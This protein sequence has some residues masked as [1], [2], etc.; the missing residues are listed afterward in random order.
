MGLKILSED[1]RKEVLKLNLKTP[2]DIVLGLVDL[3]GAAMYA[4]YLDALGKDAIIKTD[5]ASVTL[6]DPG[7]VVTD[8]IAPRIKDLNKNLK[9]PNDIKTGI[10]DL[11][12]SSAITQQYLAGRGLDTVI[13]D[14]NVINPGDVV[15]DSVTPRQTIL[16][17]NIKTPNDITTGIGNLTSNAGLT[18]QYL[19]GRGLD[20]VIGD[21][22]VFDP[23]TV[24][25]AANIERA[26]LLKKNKPYDSNDPSE[27]NSIYF[28]LSDG[29][30]TYT[31]LLDTINKLTIINDLS[32]PNST[33]VSID[34]N[35]TALVTL[36]LALQQNRYMPVQY[37]TF[38]STIIS[39]Q[40][41]LFTKPYIDAFNSGVYTFINPE[42]YT[43]SSFLSLRTTTSP[44]SIISGYNTDPISYFLNSSAT[45]ILENETL[46][47]NIAALELK[48][49]LESR[50]KRAIERET[51]GRTYLD[52]AMTNPLTAL[53]LLTGK[54]PLFEANYDITVPSNI[55]GKGAEF[56]ASLAGIT[57]PISFIKDIN[58]D[59]TP[60]CFGNTTEYDSRAKT[61]IGR[62]V[63]DL[64]GKTARSDKDIWY[65]NHTGSGQK[66]ALFNT[67]KRN[68][69]QPDYLIDYQSG[70]FKV[71]SKIAQFFKGITGF[72]GVGSGK[73]PTGFYYIGNKTR[74]E[75][76]FYLLQDADGDQV[77]S[78]EELI[79]V[80][81]HQVDTGTN[82]TSVYEEPGYD[83]VSQYGSLETD[84]VWKSSSAIDVVY[85]YKTKLGKH[86]NVKFTDDNK[87]SYI[88]NR[89]NTFRECSILYKTSQLLEKGI[90][91]FG[92]PIDQ[93]L[94]KF[95]DGYDFTSRGNATIAPVKIDKFNKQGEV[96]GYRYLIP[97]LDVSGKRNE[98]AM[99]YQAELCRV[100][101]KA[102]PYSKITDLVRYKELIRRERNSVLDR[103]GNLNIHP[104]ELNVN[105]GYGREKGGFAA[106]QTEAFGEKRARKYMFSLENLAW[107]D[108]AQFTDLPNCEKGFNG[109]RVMWFPPYDITF[110]D[111]T[112]ANWTTHQFLGRPEPIYTYNNSERSGS[113]SWKIVV[114]HPSI[115]NLLTQKELAKLTDGEID[116][117]LAAFWA[118]CVEFD[119]FELARIWNQFSQS[120][121][122]YFK[123]VIAGLN[124]KIP[125]EAIKKKIEKITVTK[126]P[127]TIKVDSTNDQAV[128][129]PSINGRS[130]FFENDVPLPID[131]YNKKD[132]L[133]NT[134]RIEKFSLYFKQYT[135]LSNGTLTGSD[136]VEKVKV[137]PGSVSDAWIRYTQ[138]IGS[139]SA[140]NYF[141]TSDPNNV[142]VDKGNWY[143]FEQQYKD[144]QK[145]LSDAKYKQFDLTINLDAYA[146]P[147]GPDKG[148]TTYNEDLANR[149]INSV[150]IWLVLDVLSKVGDI[151]DEESG[152]NLVNEKFIY[153]SEGF[154]TPI[155][156]TVYRDKG[157]GKRS[158]ILFNG[159]SNATLASTIFEE[160]LKENVNQ[161]YPKTTT[162]SNKY[163]E[164]SAPP[165]GD[166]S[167]PLIKFCCFE[168]DA[169]AEKVKKDGLLP[170]TP[171]TQIGSVEAKLN[172]P[173]EDVVCGAL[174]IVTSHARRVQISVDVDY[175]PPPPPT[176]EVVPEPVDEYTTPP[177]DVP[178][179]DRNVTKREIAQ[180]ILNK[181]INECDYFE[182]LKKDAPIVYDSL[183]QKLKYFSPAFHA[184][185]PEGLNARLTFLQQCL[186]PGET[187][188]K[189]DNDGCDANNTAFGK[190]P[191]CILRIGDFYNTKIVISNLNISYEPLIWDLNPEGIGV[192]PM[193]ADIQ[194]SFKY[195][196]GSGLRKHVDELQNALS[197]NY[198]ANTDIYDERTFANNDKDE[199]NLINL[200]RSYFDSNTLDLIPIVAAAERIV[201]QDF[202]S[203]IPYGTIGIITKRRQPTTAGG[204]YNNDILSAKTFSSGTV[205]QPYDIVS[206]GGKFYVR[207]ADDELNISAKNTLNGS[208]AP[209]TSTTHW[210]EVIWRN[211]GEQPFRLEFSK[212]RPNINENGD[213]TTGTTT[214][215]ST[216][217]DKYMSKT[218]FNSY[219][220][221]YYELFQDLYKTYGKIVTNNFKFNTPY[222]KNTLLLQLALNKN[223]N[224]TL[225]TVNSAPLGL[226]GTD[227]SG[228]TDGSSGT[229]SAS[230]SSGTSSARGTDGSSS[231]SDTGYFD[232]L[233]KLAYQDD[234]FG[235][236]GTASSSGTSSTSS[237][238]GTDGTS[239]GGKYYLYEVF[240]NEA[241]ERNYVEFSE[242][243]KLAAVNNQTLGTESIAPLKLHLYPQNN[244][245]KIGDGKTVVSTSGTF[246]DATRFN[247]GNLNGG[248]INGVNAEPEVAGIF[249]KD[250]SNH[251]KNIDFMINGLSNEMSAKLKLDIAHFWHYDTSSKQA[252]NEYLKYFEVP[253]K[254]I[255]SDYLVGKLMDYTATITDHI[256]TILT[257]AEENTAK[258]GVLLSALSVVTEGYDLRTDETKIERF[259]VIPNDF[260]I[261]K[262]EYSAETVFGYDPYQ[263]YQKMLL[264]TAET[265]KTG[266]TRTITLKKVRDFVYNRENSDADKINLLS[267]GNGPYF[268][269]QI[270]K[271]AEFKKLVPSG[272]TQDN[273]LVEST[274]IK[275]NRVITGSTET[276]SL[277]PN[278]LLGASGI[279]LNTVYDKAGG[280]GE[281]TVKSIQPPAPVPGTYSD[282]YNMTYT[283]E[284]INY[285][286]FDFSNKMLDIMVNDNFLSKKFDLDITYLDG[287][288]FA[289]L[290]FNDNFNATD[291]FYYGAN[292]N[293]LNTP[294]SYYRINTSSVGGTTTERYLTEINEFIKYNVI[295]N[296]ELVKDLSPGKT[297]LVGEP[298][299][300][301]GLVDMFFVGFFATLDDND[302]ENILKLIKAADKPKKG[303]TSG[304]TRQ[305]NSR[306][307][308]IEKTLT[309]TFKAIYKYRD[310]AIKKTTTLNTDY[311]KNIKK[312]NDSVV[313]IITETNSGETIL[314]NPMFFESNLTRGNEVDYTLVLKDTVDVKKSV[315]DNYKIFTKYRNVFNIINQSEVPEVVEQAT[316]TELSKYNKGE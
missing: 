122:D 140:E 89:R 303:V 48:F 105:D 123:K 119:I 174:S 91:G 106:A 86:I 312:V 197:F 203:D 234:K 175:T 164:V 236:F 182:L 92:S 138:T 304:S 72:L 293:L 36:D 87:L 298:I 68:K 64:I 181:L 215:N 272:Y 43:P 213:A 83:Q 152:G 131:N 109:G 142:G 102:K 281:T 108:T 10:G 277:R 291:L 205:Y 42:E 52:E 269:K 241:A 221:S 172:R 224:K 134:G 266:L 166:I 235:T 253:Y 264:G 173:Y 259:E 307:R 260:K 191:I 118:G 77:K 20:T 276:S 127:E 14:F 6:K 65:L 261:G 256:D 141:L 5:K 56:L 160:G 85:D 99:Y 120:D 45:P 308:K 46:L 74:N 192:Q 54:Q 169:I 62:F 218:Y 225:V 22:S 223:Y 250:F 33:S 94:T 121:I 35:Q 15:A 189:D 144:I 100:W 135:D 296:S 90:N 155:Y 153:S 263:K 271:D 81:T 82:T 299:L 29:A 284:K 196:G 96:I 157:N 101:T 179:N 69:Y 167:A 286:V 116:E 38:E 49:N 59:Y 28:D 67:I 23:G 282:Y 185:T 88:K 47:M 226:S 27:N 25:T 193:I 201:P 230:G 151:Y 214:G 149:R 163:F 32:V 162:G 240:K 220:I 104:S 248:K 30:Y 4:A 242:F 310:D 2:P 51:I 39:L 222:D 209:V 211:Y 61:A 194:L 273:Y 8:S 154:A 133:Y 207:K 316:E 190:P 289:S 103:Y 184:M 176:P 305:V 17:K 252:Y 58:V 249:L 217:S 50:I 275:E 278:F 53:N 132:S 239:S 180:R 93:T 206:E 40:P 287:I 31:S 165:V 71:G 267:M 188:K 76:P 63:A 117:I 130:L 210:N 301:S 279:T 97:G 212:T 208:G 265:L 115:L 199:R 262:G 95:Y 251:R 125:N 137:F 290:L 128:P 309:S 292:K 150:A 13:N 245:Y 60:K 297:S 158:K 183:K 139:R 143:G 200:E 229:S 70:V 306:Y 1:Y 24:D 159:N 34:S 243:G 161:K 114:D 231:N 11:T 257:S 170:G 294:I 268:F 57:S 19:A 146:S 177:G 244:L 98:E 186:R 232:D 285:E 3:S 171:K 313:K 228:G 80:I 129:V 247:P 107:R 315:L 219:E 110:T 113:L 258:F 295:I 44:I 112:T 270:T 216:T 79:R 16:N 84:F 227:G 145:D 12:G 55:I 18:Q 302:K 283:F 311:T 41:D 7:N 66:Y 187:I 168:S 288:D 280:V 124:V 314:D 37:N 233:S 178:T 254:A 237:T 136:S 21:K 300:V 9:T 156:F 78:N 204:A 274:A 255:F 73:A 75:D 202:Q 238:S 111:D 198:Y 147:L 126:Q 246:N 26:K 195:I 148:T